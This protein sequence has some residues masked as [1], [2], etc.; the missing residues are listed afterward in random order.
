MQRIQD[1]WSRG[2]I[3]KLS[4][5]ANGAKCQGGKGGKKLHKGHCPFCP[6]AIVRPW[7]SSTSLSIT[8]NQDVSICE[9]TFTRVTPNLGTIL[10]YVLTTKE[11][12][13]DIPRMMI[14][15]D[16]M[17]LLLSDH[18]LVS[19]N[20][21]LSGPITMEKQLEPRVNQEDSNKQTWLKTLWTII[22]R[23]LTGKA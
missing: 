20:I 3:V 12:K 15:E 1:K 13:E 18:V 14:N 6:I 11:C 23:M 19:L 7:W 2:L 5:G 8:I 9:G 22:W 16:R 21:K 17:I 4:G 10:D